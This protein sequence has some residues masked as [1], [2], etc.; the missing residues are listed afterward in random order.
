MATGYFLKFFEDGRLKTYQHHGYPMVVALPND[1]V[2]WSD[3]VSEIAP[4]IYSPRMIK[5]WCGPAGT[6]PKTANAD[7]FGWAVYQWLFR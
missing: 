6:L 4:Q 5:V 7:E 2:V 3:D 1:P